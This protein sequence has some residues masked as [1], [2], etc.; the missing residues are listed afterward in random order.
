EFWGVDVREAFGVDQP[1]EVVNNIQTHFL[2]FALL[3]CPRPAATS[4]PPR[5]L[6]VDLACRQPPSTP[7]PTKRPASAP[8]HAGGAFFA[9]SQPDLACDVEREQHG[10]PAAVSGDR[11]R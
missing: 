9:F 11:R 1:K 10:A 2:P 7:P 8:I 6:G 5:S 3:A 4:T